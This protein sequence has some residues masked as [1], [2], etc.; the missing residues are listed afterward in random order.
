MSRFIFG[1]KN[2][3]YIIDLEKTLVALNEACEYLKQLAQRGETILLVGTKK[4]AQEIIKQ[5]AEAVGMPYVHQ[6]WLGGMLTNFETI[7]KSIRRLE[8][9]ESMGREGTYRFITKKEAKELEKEREKLNKVLCGV[10]TMKQLPAVVFVV[11]PVKEDIAVR[12]ARK[13][14]IPIVA[15]IDTNCDPDPIDYPIPGNDDAI[16]SI[17]LIMSTIRASILEGCQ[18][19]RHLTKPQEP[20]PIA[21]TP[22]VEEEKEEQS[23]AT[24][25]EPPT[26]E[27]VEGGELAPKVEE[28]IETVEEE[29]VSKLEDEDTPSAKKVRTKKESG[30]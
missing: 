13:L 5:V 17:N 14:N 29:V 10:R 1:E 22:P 24:S 26:G 8:H 30:T 21:V 4:Q 20:E 19:Y 9:I 25:A 27:A 12:E 28:I 6:R 15:L 2:G 11:D 18:E 7:Q 3:I 23:I 16:R